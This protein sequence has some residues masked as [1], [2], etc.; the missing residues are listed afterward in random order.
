MPGFAAAAP[1]VAPRDPQC[2]AFSP[3]GA[4]IALGFSGMANGDFPPRPHPDVRKCGCIQIHDAASGQRLKRIETFGDIVNLAFSPDG[5]Y[6]ASARV[7]ASTESIDLSE[8]RVFS[9]P[10]GKVIRV[11]D[12]CRQFAFHPRQSRLM[13]LGRTKCV[14]FDLL[15]GNR[16]REISALQEA[17]TIAFVD[18]QQL[19]GIIRATA[20]QFADET[21]SPAQPSEVAYALRVV[22]YATGDRVAD[23]VPL[24][25][26]VFHIAVSPD[27]KYLATGL[28]GGQTLLW[29]RE[30]LRPVAAF[31]S[32][33]R[34]IAHPFFSPTG[35]M[36]AAGDQT[37][38]DVVMW[39]LARGNELFRYT[40]EKGSFRTHYARSEKELERPERDP[41]RFAF[42]PD[43]EAFLTGC[44][45]GILRLVQSGQEVRRFSE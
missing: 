8:V 28:M 4:Y 21:S 16:L 20:P 35:D 19:V 13:V 25:Q 41:A 42:S 27:A 30:E 40:F 39:N 18:A 17:L 15:F 6:L 36:L 44:Y 38:G 9:V 22:D 34:G 32:G 7:F 12:R 29:N 2:V 10:D 3:D 23:S 5:K 37:T 1:F 43:G 33:T 26:P 24:P 11:F 45:G 14:E 31:K